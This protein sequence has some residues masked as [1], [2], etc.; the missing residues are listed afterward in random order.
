MSRWE[1]Q[2]FAAVA[3]KLPV[4]WTCAAHSHERD[5]QMLVLLRGE[6]EAVVAGREYRAGVGEVLIYPAGVEH[7]ERQVGARPVDAIFVGFRRSAEGGADS[8]E[9]PPIHARDTAG[10]ASRLASWMVER[11]PAHDEAAQDFL[12]A[13]LD[14]LL[15]ELRTPTH[16][17]DLVGRVRSFVRQNLASELSLE[18]LARVAGLSRYRFAHV[19]RD[20]SG[21][22]PAAFVRLE[23]LEAARTLV[24]E[25]R[26]P[27]KAIAEQTG[28]ADEFHLSKSFRRAWSRPPSEWRKR[29]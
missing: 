10:H 18:K 16:A 8:G 1:H 2:C 22:A 13:Q 5:W 9:A 21:L 3:V 7:A 27:L 15:R 29:T 14:L 20:A 25:T 28:F 4:G 6:M 11:A 23:R 26:L 24:A 17:D 19:F 12:D